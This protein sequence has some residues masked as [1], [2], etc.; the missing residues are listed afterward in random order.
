MRIWQ[1]ATGRL[2][3]METMRVLQRHLDGVLDELTARRVADHLEE[4]RRCGLE[5]EVYRQIKAAL[6]RQGRRTDPRTAER[7]ERIAEQLARGTLFS[8]AEH[9]D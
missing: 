6:A 2:R 4:C 7:L 9:G 8:Q 5:A 3:C 1:A